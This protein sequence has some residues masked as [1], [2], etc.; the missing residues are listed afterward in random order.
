MVLP[1]SY[2]RY[3]LLVGVV[4][5]SVVVFVLYCMVLGSCSACFAMSSSRINV[6]H[7]FARIRS[8]IDA[9]FP[10]GISIP[11][12]LP[13]GH[14]EEVPGGGSAGSDTTVVDGPRR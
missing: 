1:C 5:E 2:A 14:E 9:L 3:C 4:A 6:R 10:L 7:F 13:Q 8:C 11:T 12:R